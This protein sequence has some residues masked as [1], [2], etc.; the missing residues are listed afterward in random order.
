[1]G[2]RLSIAAG[3]VAGVIVALALLVAFVFVGPDPGQ[4]RA[5][6]SASPAAEADASGAPSP[7]AVPSGAS[8]SPIASGGS[9]AVPNFHMGEPAP[10]LIVPQVGGGTIDLVV[11]KGQPVWIT[12]MQTTSEP[13]KVEFPLMQGFADRYTEQGLAVIAIDVREDEET[14]LA[15]AQGLDS[16]LP[17]GLD[18]DGAAQQG[19]GAFALPMHYWIDK[20]GIVQDAASGGIGAETMVRGL[21]KILP[22]VE[23][24]P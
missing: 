6:A 17:L 22:G 8:A 13:S 4:P 2:S 20:D 23:V 1:M 3:L 24:T 16:T 12:F 10:S 5:S 21:T 19:W 9:G 18:T 11:L 14:V 7:S 15:F